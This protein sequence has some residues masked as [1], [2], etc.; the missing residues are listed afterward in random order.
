MQ[1]TNHIGETKM[2]DRFDRKIEPRYAVYFIDPETRE[3]VFSM[4]GPDRK[5]MELEAE[6]I[7]DCTPRMKAIVIKSSH[8]NDRVDPYHQADYPP[9]KAFA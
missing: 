3:Y 1:K 6:Y 7:N 4:S 2:T 8:P 5:A 9:I